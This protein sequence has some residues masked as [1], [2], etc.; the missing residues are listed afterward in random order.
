VPCIDASRAGDCHVLENTATGDTNFTFSVACIGIQLLQT[1]M[2]WF[3]LRYS[4]HTSP[5]RR[6]STLSDEKLQDKVFCLRV[7]AHDVKQWHIS[8]FYSRICQD[9]TVCSIHIFYVYI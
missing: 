6:D 2:H 4:R 7:V 1:R 8:E 3:Q 9:H 5:W